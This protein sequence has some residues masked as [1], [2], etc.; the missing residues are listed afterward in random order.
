M[1]KYWRKRLY[2]PNLGNSAII[3]VKSFS[4]DQVLFDSSLSS[5]TR[6]CTF[7]K[8]AKSLSSCDSRLLLS[9]FVLFGS[10]K[11]VFEEFGALFALCFSRLSF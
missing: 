6:V 5:L 4:L 3:G 10:R 7:P 1:L 2:C 9:Y 11:A 8:R